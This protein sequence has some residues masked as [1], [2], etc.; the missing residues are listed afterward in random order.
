MPTDGDTSIAQA[1]TALVKHDLILKRCSQEYNRR[2]GLPFH[3]LKEKKCTLVISIKLGHLRNKTLSTSHFV[4]WDG[5][6]IWDHPDRVKINRTSDQHT[7]QGIKDVFKKLYYKKF[8]SWQI[9][10]VYQL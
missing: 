3:L 7:V 6:T 1:N 8:S 9:A 5:N 2:G 10:N 4:A